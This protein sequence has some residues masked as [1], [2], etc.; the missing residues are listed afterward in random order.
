MTTFTGKKPSEWTTTTKAAVKEA[1]DIGDRHRDSFGT[2]STVLQGGSTWTN[3]LLRSTKVS[4]PHIAKNDYFAYK[5]Q[6][7]HDKKLLTNLDGFHV[8]IIPVGAVSGGEV[9]H[10]TYAWG[11]LKNG[12]TYPDTLPNTGQCTI[13]LS[14]GDQFKYLIKGLVSNMAYPTSEGYSS[15][16]FIE[17][18]RSNDGNDT[19][20]GEFAL[21]DG[22]AHYLTNRTGSKYEYSDT[23]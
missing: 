17:F 8:H 9:I 10:M 23:P 16:L 14:A 7:N 22:D 15:E 18:H 20:S 12:D 13:T 2:L 21:V 11:W 3:R 4:A 19:Y 1:I 6:F 5:C